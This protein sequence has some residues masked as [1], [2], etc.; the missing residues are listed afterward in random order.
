MSAVE[1]IKS[2][3]LDRT[4]INCQANMSFAARCLGVKSEISDTF[5]YIIH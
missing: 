1:A 4:A 3:S 2:M 5:E